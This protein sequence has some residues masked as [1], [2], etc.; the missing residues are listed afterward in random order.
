M[1]YARKACAI[2]LKNEPVLEKGVSDRVLG[3]AFLSS[4]RPREALECYE[5]AMPLLESAHDDEDLMLARAG[6]QQA[7]HKLGPDTGEEKAY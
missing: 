1:D 2:A 7:A 6:A 3:D 5:R 4:G